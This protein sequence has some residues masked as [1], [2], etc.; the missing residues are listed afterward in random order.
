LFSR[1]YSVRYLGLQLY[2]LKSY[3]QHSTVP[4]LTGTNKRMKNEGMFPKNFDMR[5]MHHPKTCP[6]LFIGN[7]FKWTSK[8]VN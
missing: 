1:R 6:N 8:I 3:D 5:L 2:C 7:G 4:L